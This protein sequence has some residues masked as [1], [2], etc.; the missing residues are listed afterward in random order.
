MT[1]NGHGLVKRAKDQRKRNREGE[2]VKKSR[3]TRA[4]MEK[5]AQGY[6]NMDN[7]FPP[8]DR[9]LGHA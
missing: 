5:E 4:D 7:T 1:K 2:I 9:F 6:R 8:Y 3:E